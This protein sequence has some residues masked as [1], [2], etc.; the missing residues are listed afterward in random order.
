MRLRI[1]GGC[2]NFAFLQMYG[3]AIVVM[4]LHLAQHDTDALWT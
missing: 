2:L 4:L 3:V 1:N